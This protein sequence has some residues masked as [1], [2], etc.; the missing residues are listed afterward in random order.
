M[1]KTL[2]LFLAIVV[3]TISKA[4]QMWPIILDDVTTTSLQ[5]YIVGDFRVNDV[6]NHLYIWSSG[7]TYNVG[8]AAGLNFF[9]NTEGYLDLTVAA[10]DGWS[11]MGF[12]I[13]NAASVAAMQS[14]KDAIVANPNNYYLHIAMKATTPGNHQFYIFGTSETSFA[15][16]TGTIENGQVIGDFPRDGTWHEF[17]IPMAQYANAIA[18]SDIRLG[19]NILCVLS[20]AQV[21]A[22]LNLDA[23][24][25][26]DQEV[27]NEFPLGSRCGANLLWTVTNDGVLSITGYG[28]MYDFEIGKTPWDKMTNE[29]Q[30]IN[31]SDSVTS[32]GKYA[33]S[34]CSNLTSITIPGSVTSI[35]DCA[36]VLCNNLTSVNI[37]NSVTNIGRYIFEGSENLTSIIAP[38]KIF[39]GIYS[40]KHVENVCVNGGE[41]TESA[42]EYIALSYKTL[43]SIDVS[44]TTNTE[45]ADE[46]FSGCYNL[47]SL[48]L[49]A[50]LSE[51]SYMAV[52]GCKSLQA[53]NIP[54]S[55]T[56][57]GPS[58]FE[59]CRSLSAVN[60]AA[61][62]A[63]TSIGNWAF[64]N[65]HALQNIAIPDG[66]T[67]IGS[68]A[69]YGCTYL[70]ELTLPASVQ[71]IGDNAFALCSRMQKITVDAVV[72]PT[73]ADKTF[74]EVSLQ[75]PVYVPEES[76]QA[77]QSDPLWGRMNI[78][79]AHT[80]VENATAVSTVIRKELINGKLFILLPDGSKYSAT[81]VKVE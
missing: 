12:S 43:K 2:F 76:V 36:F 61:N 47:Q 40:S 58:A 75:T 17:Y 53:I 33:F 50:N 49:P 30:S 4:A 8:N 24:Y 54:A 9:G 6:D 10:P 78:V 29:I 35:G 13:G 7:E 77:Y 70:A 39:E 14:L 41:L 65:C 52:A 38:A 59:N 31:L 73:I 46:A 64:Y 37:P 81:G 28:D 66:V 69:F 48:V 63:I 60:F 44:A 18:N 45:L 57:I 34:N 72:P 80:H 25:F 55:V 22:Q 19:I 56:E 67:S 5:G 32:I 15:I 20:G 26:C 11:G 27:V 71:H 16:G 3:A 21:G 74:F 68:G 23:V 42:F 62:P 79:G 1:K 51:I